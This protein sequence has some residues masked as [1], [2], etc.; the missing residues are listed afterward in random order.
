MT[1]DGSRWRIATT[2]DVGSVGPAIEAALLGELLPRYA[3]TNYG[4]FAVVARD[5]AQETAAGLIASTS[6]GWLL[7]GALWVRPHLRRAGLGAAMMAAAEA[8]GR[9]RA[10]HGAWLDTSSDDA[11][12]FYERLGYSVFGSL[13]N[14]PGRPPEA[15]ARWFLRKDLA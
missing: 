1:Q 5:G 14:G 15:H 6:Y 4:R 11:R 3:E 9:A 8:E 7:I 2:D 12:R 10:C 13:R